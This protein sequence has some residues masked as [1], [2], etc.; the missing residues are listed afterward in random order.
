MSRTY[1]RR[2]PKLR[3]AKDDKHFNKSGTVRDGTYTRTAGSCENHGGCPYC[4]SN[5]FHS[6]RKREPLEVDDA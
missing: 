2:V 1:R 3:Y 6:D 4:E 5:K